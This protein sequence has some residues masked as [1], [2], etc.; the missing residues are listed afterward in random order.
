MRNIIVTLSL[1]LVIS[2]AG[3]K[4]AGRY[5]GPSVTSADAPH[6]CDVQAAHPADVQRFAPGK[7]DE[8]IVP[9]IAVRACT[10][11]VNQFSDQPRFQ[12]QLGRAQLAMKLQNEAMKSFN[13]AASMGYAPA[14]FYLAEAK[15]E[16]YWETESETDLAEIETLLESAGS[17]PPAVERLGQVK[18]NADSFASPR[19]IE[20]L[21]NGD[22]ERLN[23]SRLLVALYLRGLHNFLATE[24]NPES[25]DCPA[26]VVDPS[27]TFN[28][29]RAIAGDPANT[30]EGGKYF[31]MI[32][33]AEYGGT[34]IWDPVWKGS[35]DKWVEY[36]EGLGRRDGLHLAHVCGCASPV[37][38]RLYRNLRE[39]SEEQK[40]LS[41]YWEGMLRGDAQELFS[42][43][44][45]QTT[46]EQD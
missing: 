44:E 20:A 13:V 18:F 23:R 19:I 7:T 46:E 11:A 25:Q 45:P 43:Q 41:E 14:N 40:P 6:E 28:L 31:L 9:V 21:W 36:Y 42:K 2:I 37:T 15:L 29:D 39:M 26:Y 8:E 27:I 34:L 35:R 16:S 38:S 33:A 5:S 1:L 4:L 12:F 22:Y 17:F 10:E 32:K 3:C 30:L 24:F